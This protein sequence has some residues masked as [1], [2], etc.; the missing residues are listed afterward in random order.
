MIAKEEKIMIVQN[1]I[2]QS[3]RSLYESE[4]SLKVEKATSNNPQQVAFYE[5]QVKNNLKAIEI[6]NL[7][8]ESLRAEE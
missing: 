2:H 5:T 7:E 3:E 6:L 1:R 8:L 4:L